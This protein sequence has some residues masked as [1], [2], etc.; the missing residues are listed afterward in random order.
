VLDYHISEIVS[1]TR[2]YKVLEL[3]TCS[4]QTTETRNRGLVLKY[5]EA[6]YNDAKLLKEVNSVDMCFRLR[7]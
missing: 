3:S 6:T 5:K 4:S 7:L 1:D 2:L